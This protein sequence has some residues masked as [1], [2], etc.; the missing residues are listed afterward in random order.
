VGITLEQDVQ[1]SRG[2]RLSND[3]IAELIRKIEGGNSS[4][5]L[6]LYDGT[7]RLIFGLVVRILSDRASAEETLLDIY[8]QV[9][10]QP[11]L[12]GSGILPLD[13]L[14]T[15]AWTKALARL[16]WNGQDN[17]KRDIGAGEADP[18]MTVAPGEQRDARLALESLPSVQQEL[19]EWAYYGGMSCNEMAA[20]IGKPLGAVKSH[21]KAGLS[22]LSEN[23]SPDAG[24][25]TNPEWQ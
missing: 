3:S 13:W 16:Q 20:Q 7:S 10:K 14:V 5:L 21:I 23:L 2:L 19:L 8:T 1:A 6:A 22:R 12:G 4:A 11:P 9:W 18:A 25:E 15:L 17:R 24:S